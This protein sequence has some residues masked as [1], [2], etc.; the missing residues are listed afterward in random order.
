MKDSDLKHGMTVA[1]RGEDKKG[2]DI[3]RG[4]LLSW[5]EHSEDREYTIKITHHNGIPFDS[6]FKIIGKTVTWIGP[7]FGVIA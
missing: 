5:T 6:K 7:L 4:E 2:V 3:I 1:F